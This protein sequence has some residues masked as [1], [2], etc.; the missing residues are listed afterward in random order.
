M[1]TKIRLSLTLLLLLGTMLTGW[2]HAFLDHAKPAVGSQIHNAPPQVKV[3]FTE[4]LKPALSCL[5]VFDAA[6]QRVDRRDVGV[7]RSDPT[8]LEVSLPILKP[9][10]YRVSWQ[11][12]SVD[13]HVTSGTFSFEIIP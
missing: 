8:I 9:G 4:K 6:G 5:Q 10:K 1:R 2:T 11:V 13:T 12:M 3:W 7:D